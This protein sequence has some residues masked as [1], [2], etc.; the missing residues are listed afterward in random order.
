M[1][2]DQC[3]RSGEQ[4]REQRM[5]RRGEGI[6]DGDSPADK[7][8][9]QIPGEQQTAARIGRRGE[10]DRIPDAELVADYKVSRRKHDLQGRVDQRRSSVSPAQNDGASFLP[11]TPAFAKKDQ[12]QFAEDLDR[13][14]EIVPGNPA[15]EI[16]GFRHGRRIVDSFGAGKDVGIEGDLQGTSS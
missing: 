3:Q 11:G 15:D 10:D 6:C 12:K 8:V 5:G 14:D 4:G 9:L 1:P 2:R 16:Q 13:E 7:S